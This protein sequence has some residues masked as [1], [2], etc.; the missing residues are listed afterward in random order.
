MKFGLENG[1]VMN[2][3]DGR[4]LVEA[5]STLRVETL[6]RQHE[7]IGLLVLFAAGVA[8]CLL[9]YRIFRVVL[10]LTGFLLAGLTA[11]ALAGWLSYGHV[12]SMTIAGVLGGLCGAVALFFL[13]RTGVFFVGF[14]G[15]VII[16]FHV[17][18]GHSESWVLWAILGSGLAGGVMALGLEP[19]VMT[20]ATAVIGAWLCMVSGFFLIMGS[21]YGEPLSKPENTAAVSWGLLIIWGVMACIGILVQFR[22]GK[23]SRKQ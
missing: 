10:G 8:Y 12:L 5:L 1:M 4:T 21:P 9:G 14:L 11:A 20:V 18:Q 2:R 16:A 3:N 7:L 15:G 23:S 17:L 22:T 13:Y 6:S 19:L